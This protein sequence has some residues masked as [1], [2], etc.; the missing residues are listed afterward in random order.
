LRRYFD[1]GRRA[2]DRDWIP[3]A[4]PFKAGPRPD[5]EL[6]IAISG[7]P[8]DD[9]SADWLALSGLRLERRAADR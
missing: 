8:Q 9:L 4:I 1:A 5:N 3:L 7:G 6:I 2:E